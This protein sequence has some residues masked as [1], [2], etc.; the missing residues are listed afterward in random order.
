MTISLSHPHELNLKFDDWRDGQIKAIEWIMQDEWFE[1]DSTWKNPTNGIEYPTYEKMDIKVL[2]G[3]TGTGKTGVILAAALLSGKR[4]LIMCATKIE[5]E[6]YMKNLLSLEENISVTTVKGKSN[7]HCVLKEQVDAEPECESQFCSLIHKDEAP[8]GVEGF[9]CP[10]RNLCPYEIQ[11]SRAASS[12]I[13]VTNYAYGLAMLNY[14]GSEGGL[15]IRDVIVSDEGHVLDEM[16]EQFIS[17]RLS[18]RVVTKLFNVSLPRFPDGG[19]IPNWKGWIEDTLPVLRSSL[20]KF[21][22]V[23]A[24][25]MDKSERRDYF[26]TMRYLDM[27]H[28]ITEL[29]QNWVVEEDSN[30][31]VFQPVWVTA[32]SRDVLF[33]HAG[34]HIIMS[35]TIPSPVELG[36]KV[37]LKV[38]DFSFYRLPYTFPPENRQIILRPRVDLSYKVKQA[39]LPILLDAVDEVLAENIF[40]KVLIHTKSY[41]IAK[42][43]AEHSEYGDYFL[44]H[45][46]RTRN[47]VLERFKRSSPPAILASPS[48]D[49]AIDLPGAECELI[50]IAKVPFPYLGSK[51]MKKRSKNR[52]YYTHETLMTIIQMAGRGVRSEIDV[53]PTIVLDAAGPRFFK[54]ARR[55][56]PKG[57]QEAIIEEERE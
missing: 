15:G 18:K 49:K 26:A 44:L 32:D 54:Q 11:K 5:Q 14:I 24:E 23:E 3:P 12:Q 57:I 19:D 21:E 46:T 45:D 56:I 7:F 1:H 29:D 53:C 28:K 37:G 51:V 38:D 50:I 39:N 48:F 43:L 10:V 42:Y 36:S 9:K 40:R 22:G 8:C 16:L 34:R 31:I 35:G 55:M 17:V 41:D 52:R 30:Q 20:D 13:V 33:N 27:F 25:D 2:E 4:V 6:Q 47:A